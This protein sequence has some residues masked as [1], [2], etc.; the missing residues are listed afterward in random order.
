MST[1]RQLGVMPDFAIYHYY[2]Q[3][4]PS[5][6]DNDQT[7]LMS[8]TGNWA[9][10]AA[11]LRGDI[12]DFLGSAG[13]NVEVLVTENNNDEGTP[14]KQSVSLVNA[15]YYADSLG[16]IM[17][18][19]INAR[20][21]WQLHDG[22]P[23]YNNGDLDSSLY[24]WRQYGAFGI[25]DW[26]QGL[27]MT[28]RYPPYFAAEL[29][30]HFI[31]GG[32]TVVSAS[33]N[34]PAVTAYAA[35]RTN[36]SLALL[37]INK[38]PTSNYLANIVLANYMPGR[39]AT[40]YSYGMPQDNAAKVADNINCDITTNSYSVSTNFSYT[41][42]PYSI[43]VFA[44]APLPAPTQIGGI[45]VSGDQFVFSYPTVTGQT[46]QLQYT[47]DLDS[48]AWLPAGSAVPGTGT[49]VSVTNSVSSSTQMFFRLSVTTP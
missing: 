5:S 44:F 3:N 9:G 46:Y 7:L 16:Q 17:Q 6:G 31:R 13:T 10:D 22:G 39:T 41:L 28:N 48:G 15:L 24:G 2:P 21:W 36:G 45:S 37:A 4:Y 35:L 14:G 19:E 43:T 12:N 40:V 23:A 30:S 25:M 42:A 34:N 26:E 38:S 11:E 47:T 8:E 33:C 18:T 20:V 1:L 49:P 32:D 27:Q 29:I